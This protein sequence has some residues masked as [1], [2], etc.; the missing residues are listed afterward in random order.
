MQTKAVHR[1]RV[2]GALA[3]ARAEQQPPEAVLDALLKRLRAAI[4]AKELSALEDA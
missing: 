2:Q 4:A 3:V 1:G